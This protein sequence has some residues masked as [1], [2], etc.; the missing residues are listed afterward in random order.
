MITKPQWS[1]AEGVCVVIGLAIVV[2][3]LCGG[4]GGGSCG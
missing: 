4:R 3:S 2:V 1:T